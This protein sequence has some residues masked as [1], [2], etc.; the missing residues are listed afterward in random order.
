MTSVTPLIDPIGLANRI[1]SPDLVLIDVRY[2]LAGPP[3]NP[4][5]EAGHVPGSQYV[6]LDAELSA[7]RRSDGTGGR[8]PLPE[9]SDLQATLQR[10][11][12]RNESLVVAYDAATSQ[13]AARLW[14]LLT[15]AGHEKTRVLNGGFAAWVADGFPVQSGPAHPVPPGDFVVQPGRRAQLDAD[16]VAAALAAG[17]PVVDVRVEE[18]YT[19]QREVIDPVAGHIPGAVNRP[20]ADN[21]HPDGRFRTAAEIADRFSGLEDPVLYCGSGITAAHTLLALESAGRTGAIYPG[22]W[23]DWISDPT[24][25]VRRT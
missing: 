13:S 22:S 2:T 19:G 6:D 9:A 1:G 10:L 5:Y 15:D 7:P 17:R 8:H 25:P 11:G 21:T 20:S 18:R 14:W 24:R 16:Q 3:G 4:E 23:S 12:V